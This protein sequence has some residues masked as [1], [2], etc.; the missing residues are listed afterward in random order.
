MKTVHVMLGA[1]AKAFLQVRDSFAKVGS[2][3]S[4]SLYT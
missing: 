2:F 3:E 1:L 4:F